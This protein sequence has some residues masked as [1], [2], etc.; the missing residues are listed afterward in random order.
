MYVDR[1]IPGSCLGDF[2]V[3]L[4]PGQGATVKFDFTRRDISYWDI[5]TQQW[6]IGS[7]SISAMAGFSSRDIAATVSFTPLS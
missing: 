4:E 2:K 3:M 6:M 1:E 7:G 5:F